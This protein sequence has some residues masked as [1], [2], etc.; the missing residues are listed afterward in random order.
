MNS[1]QLP[2]TRKKI[3][4]ERDILFAQNAG[5]KQKAATRKTFPGSTESRPT[6][7]T[8]AQ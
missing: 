1:R 2:N 3:A 8:I 7:E 5:T 6:E 4:S